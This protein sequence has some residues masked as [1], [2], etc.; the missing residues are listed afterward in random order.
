MLQKVQ[1]KKVNDTKPDN[2]SHSHITAVEHAWM[3]DHKKKWL[4]L[5]LSAINSGS[6]LLAE[7]AQKVINEIDRAIHSSSGK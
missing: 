1:R 6:F 3:L 2:G 4:E 7:S 5:R